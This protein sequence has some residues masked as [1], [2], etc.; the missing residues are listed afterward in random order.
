MGWG[1]EDLRAGPP[2]D[3]VELPEV[4][5]VEQGG[6]RDYGVIVAADPQYRGSRLHARE[7]F[8]V[9]VFGRDGVVHAPLAG[10]EAGPVLRDRHVA[11]V[12]VL[13]R[14]CGEHRGEEVLLP[15]RPEGR[16]EVE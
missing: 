8:E 4:A 2:G 7:V 14:L 10:G 5:E 3:R 9:A 1:R 11:G 13:A 16:L 15:R 6:V 12:V